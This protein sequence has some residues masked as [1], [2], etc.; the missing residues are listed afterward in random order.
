MNKKHVVSFVLA[1]VLAVGVSHT[2]SADVGDTI[3][4]SGNT[5]SSTCNADKWIAGRGTIIQYWSVSNASGNG[6]AV[7]YCGASYGLNTI[8]ISGFD[9]GMLTAQYYAGDMNFG[10]MVS[11]AGTSQVMYSGGTNMGGGTV[12]FS[13]GELSPAVAVG[14]VGASMTEFTGTYGPLLLNIWLAMLS[15]ALLYVAYGMI[16]R[17][18]IPETKSIH[19][20]L[21]FARQ[22]KMSLSEAREYRQ[23]EHYRTRFERKVKIRR[24]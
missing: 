17:K 8:D 4:V 15:L 3:S 24:G 7:A 1:C 19:R 12:D 5:V 14:A 9:S 18:L 6:S 16:R 11:I 20:D 2:A 23:K 22:N 10:N 21:K 13:S